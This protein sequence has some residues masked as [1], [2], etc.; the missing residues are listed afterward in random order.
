VAERRVA[1]ELV[2]AGD[3]QKNQ[4]L[5]SAVGHPNVAGAARLAEQCIK[6]AL[7]ACPA[8]AAG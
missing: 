4:V 7:A 2:G 8:P 1:Y 6:A 5:L 3:L